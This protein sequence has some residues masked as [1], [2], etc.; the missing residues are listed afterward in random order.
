[1]KNI[2]AITILIIIFSCSKENESIELEPKG[3]IEA[4]INGNPYSDLFPDSTYIIQVGYLEGVQY[5]DCQGYKLASIGVAFREKN[6]PKNLVSLITMVKSP[7]EV[8]E[9]N[10]TKQ[11]HFLSY[12][13]CKNYPTSGLSFVHDLLSSPEY[14]VDSTRNNIF[15][16]SKITATT[17]EG[18][19]DIK[20]IEKGIIAGYREPSTFSSRDTVHFICDKFVAIR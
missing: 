13:V 15:R 6:K 11:Y 20:F 12:D 8:L 16:I 14:F 7:I 9:F 17:I 5:Y 10:I 4:T 19:F 2:I 18:S 1:M 3:L